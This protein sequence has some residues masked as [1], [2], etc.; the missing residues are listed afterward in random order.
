M[1]AEGATPTASV[2]GSGGDKPGPARALFAS[3][4][5]QEPLAAPAGDGWDIGDDTFGGDW[6][7]PLSNTVP[8][9]VSPPAASAR[10]TFTKK[11][12]PPAAHF[13]MKPSASADTEGWDEFDSELPAVAPKP[14][15]LVPAASAVSA[16]ERRAQLAAKRE[17]RRKTLEQTGRTRAQDVTTPDVPAPVEPAKRTGG[18]MSLKAKATATAPAPAPE[19]PKPVA[20]KLGPVVADGWDDF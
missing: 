16:E 7:A 10:T 5:S 17:E 8:K 15:T 18:G 14:V 19:A 9:K 4:T 3:P 1:E 12:S 13:A 6:D 11:A 20:K 2:S